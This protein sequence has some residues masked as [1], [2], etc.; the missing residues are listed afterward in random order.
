MSAYGT[1]A[2]LLWHTALVGMAPLIPVPFVDDAARGW[3]RRRM[4][5][6]LAEQHH[7]RL[8]DEEIAA[9]CDEGAGAF[10]KGA[11]RSVA[12]APL[13]LLLRRAF[14]LLRGKKI[15]DDASEC[16]H[17]GFLCE[18]AFARGLCA[19]L[20]PHDARALRTA[21]D[22]VLAEAPVASSPVTTAIRSA[23]ARSRAAIPRFIESLQ[24]RMTGFRPDDFPEAME[25]A[26]EGEGSG[27]GIVAELRRALAEV[28][29]EHFERLE[30]R[31]AELLGA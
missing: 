14:V 27:D 26:A 2:I 4:V 25:R 1:D 15:L 21:I 13:R 6:K 7:L 10:V 12:T 19:P 31:L 30:R 23:F 20:G 3:L 9:L 24:A 8:W 22:A 28:P 18:R 5:R 16:Y 17:R 29:R 11:V